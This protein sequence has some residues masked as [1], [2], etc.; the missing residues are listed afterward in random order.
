MRPFTPLSRLPVIAFILH[1]VFVAASC[2]RADYEQERLATPVASASVPQTDD[3]IIAL[4]GRTKGD[5]PD[6]YF[7]LYGNGTL[8][9]GKPEAESF[10]YFSAALTPD[11]VRQVY[12]SMLPDSLG[13]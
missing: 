2:S 9:F 4:V 6:P 8:I 1:S 11:Q 5:N 7:V 13:A 12:S 10:R 3:P